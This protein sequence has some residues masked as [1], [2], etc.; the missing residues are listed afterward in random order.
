MKGDFPGRAAGGRCAAAAAA[1]LFGIARLSAEGKDGSL[2]LLDMEIGDPAVRRVVAKCTVSQSIGPLR[3]PG[4]AKHA[5]F[6]VDRPPLAAAMGRRL[7]P[8]LEAYEIVQ[9]E[10]GLYGV[11]IPGQLHGTTRLVGRGPGRRVYLAKGTFRSRRLRLRLQGSA[12]MTLSFWEE[13]EEGGPVLVSESRVYVRIDNFFWRGVARLFSRALR[14]IVEEKVANLL[15][16]ARTVNGRLLSDPAG[17]YREAQ[18]WPELSD[19]QREDLRGHL[20]IPTGRSPGATG[21]ESATSR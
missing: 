21:Q 14:G 7:E 20:S 16:A 13:K 12:V 8:R 3:F 6:L 4:R 18:A 19:A 1:L 5:E 15:A 11:R 2:R 17:V 10:P 9:T